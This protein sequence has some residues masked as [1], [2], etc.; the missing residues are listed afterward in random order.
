MPLTITRSVSLKPL[1][2]KFGQFGV[3]FCHEGFA[4]GHSPLPEGFGSLGNL[5]AEQLAV[6][7]DQGHI[8]VRQAKLAC[9]GQFLLAL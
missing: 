6:F 9:A 1:P 4:V 7:T 8:I 5:L 2:L 3:H